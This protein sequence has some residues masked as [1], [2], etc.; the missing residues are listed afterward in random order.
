MSNWQYR[1][2][3]TPVVGEFPELTEL[4]EEGWELAWCF[5][6]TLDG[7]SQQ[8]RWIWKRP[9][10]PT[11]PEGFLIYDRDEAEIFAAGGDYYEVLKHRDRKARGQG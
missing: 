3:I 11:V 10:L 2:Y 6:Y 9:V 8:I 1:T 4:A 5:P 7:K